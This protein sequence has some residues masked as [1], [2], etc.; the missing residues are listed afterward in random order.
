MN[1]GRLVTVDR[2]ASSGGSKPA[3][4]LE[5]LLDGPSDTEARRG[6]RTLLSPELTVSSVALDGKTAA[7]DLTGSFGNDTGVRDRRL[8]VAQLVFTATQLPGI[9]QVRLLLDGKAVDVPDTSGKLQHGVL[10]RADF[11]EVAPSA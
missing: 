3:A 7:V 5:R 1:A 6:I 9:D 2:K 10:R 4:V 8:A 11:P